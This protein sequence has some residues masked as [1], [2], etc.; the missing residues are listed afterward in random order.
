MT[1]YDEQPDIMAIGDSM[2]QGIRS[3]S[4]LPAMVNHSTP[5]QVA[6]AI[7][8]SMTV[9]DLRQPLLFDLEA[10]LRR[11]GLLHLVEHLRG[12]CLDNL[13][14]WPLDQPWSQH[15]AFDNVAIGGAQIASLFQDTYEN[16]IDQVRDLSAKL[17][18]PN[19]SITELATTIGDLWFALNNCYTLNPRHRDA[20]RGK[21]QLD[22]VADRQPQIL[23][24]NIGSNEGLFM[25]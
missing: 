17:A 12:V 20:Q 10:E 1:T 13:K 23:L 3:I 22:Q 21:S 8:M 14:A 24:I 4:F 2:Y 18:G 11:G 7:G 9:P 16:Y 19:L 6:D 25:A 5:K 15:E